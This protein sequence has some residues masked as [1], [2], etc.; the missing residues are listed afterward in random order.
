MTNGV[1]FEQKWALWSLGILVCAI[2]AL[3][4]LEDKLDFN[5]LRR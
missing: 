2:K 5:S 4:T 1:K 3:G